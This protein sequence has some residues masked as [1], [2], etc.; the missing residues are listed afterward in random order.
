[1]IG[2]QKPKPYKKDDHLVDPLRYM[3]MSRPQHPDKEKAK[4]APVG[5]VAWLEE[6]ELAIANDWRGKYRR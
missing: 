2:E 6:R 1:M 4:V 5:S 3:I